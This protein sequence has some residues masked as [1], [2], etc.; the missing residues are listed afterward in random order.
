MKLKP[1]SVSMKSV[2]AKPTA[3]KEKAYQQLV[4]RQGVH[5]DRAKQLLGL[6]K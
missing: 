6:Q 3:P 2:V 4:T 5:P 1:I